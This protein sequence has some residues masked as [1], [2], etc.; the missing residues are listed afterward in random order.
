VFEY[1]ISQFLT[2]HNFGF[3]FSQ[4]SICQR[5]WRG[6]TPTLDEDEP[7]LVAKNFGL[8]VGFDPLWTS[9][10]RKCFI[11]TVCDPKHAKNAFVTGP[12]L[13]AH[14]APQASYSRLRMGKTPSTPL[15]PPPRYRRLLRFDPHSQQCKNKNICKN[16]QMTNTA[17]FYSNQQN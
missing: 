12:R 11:F 7:P 8:G 9:S 3:S 14:D 15:T 5:G 10:S 17:S 13:G 2:S 6:L 16:F 4:C 1:Y